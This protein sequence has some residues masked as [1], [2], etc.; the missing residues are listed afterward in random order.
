MS[1]AALQ[2]QPHQGRVRL[3]AGR[4]KGLFASRQSRGEGSSRVSE[5]HLVASDRTLCLSLDDVVPLTEL[6]AQLHRFLPDRSV[7]LQGA[8]RAVASIS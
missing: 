1:T 8:V 3:Q 7:Q 4:L 6:W 5:I 2:K